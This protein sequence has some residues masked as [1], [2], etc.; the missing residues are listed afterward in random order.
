MD[1]GKERE[2]GLFFILPNATAAPRRWVILLF[3]AVLY[4]IVSVDP[5]L[6]SDIAIWDYVGYHW[7]HHGMLPY[8]DTVEN[9]PPGIFY[10]HFLSNALLG[11]NRWFSRIVGGGL[12]LFTGWL[13]ACLAERYHGAL[14]SVLTLLLFFL[15]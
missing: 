15:V 8:R 7:V 12:L 2:G 11:V 5:F 6:Y 10:I 13:V 9:K 4:G 14:A 3:L 1:R